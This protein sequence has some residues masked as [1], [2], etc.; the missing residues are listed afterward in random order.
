MFLTKKQS[1]KHRCGFTLIELIVVISIISVLITLVSVVLEPA[2]RIRSAYEAA[3]KTDSQTISKAANQYFLDNLTYTPLGISNTPTEICNTGF[4]TGAE[5]SIENLNCDELIN[6]S[7][8]V[9]IY[10][11]GIPTNP[12]KKNALTDD[13]N[14]KPNSA[15][16]TITMTDRGTIEVAP[17][18]LK[19]RPISLEIVRGFNINNVQIPIIAL[20]FIIIFVVGFA[21][22]LIIKSRSK[23]NV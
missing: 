6:L 16:Y 9:P 2:N 20:A 10:V 13:E 19:T 22:Y 11:V 4:K 14:N 1:N 8:L 7:K 15:G 12:Q 3:Q 18:P 5:V 23:N 21:V 17:V